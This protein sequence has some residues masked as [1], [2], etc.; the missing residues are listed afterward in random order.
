MSAFD[1]DDPNGDNETP[2]DGADPTPV[3]WGSLL[4]Q[5]GAGTDPGSVDPSTGLPIFHSITG[6]P[7][8]NDDLN[9]AGFTPGG[10]Q[11]NTINDP[12]APSG[13]GSSLLDKLK[14]AVSG[15]TGGNSTG[16]K[17][18][19]SLAA[20]FVGAALGN[21]QQKRSP[22]GNAGATIGQAN[23]LLGQVTPLALGNLMRGP[24]MSSAYVQ[25]PPSFAGGGL[26]QGFGV[27]GRDP[28]A[29]GAGQ[30]QSGQDDLTK[31]MGAFKLLGIGGQ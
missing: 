13:G 31:A 28:L 19:A 10:Y 14:N 5:L 22:L 16:L 26:P 7:D 29:P 30:P 18:L 21:G 2:P 3:D 6:T 17:E 1:Y 20:P 12:T 24:D 23:S 4:P 15:G 25:Q 27:T 11:Q 8:S 9:G